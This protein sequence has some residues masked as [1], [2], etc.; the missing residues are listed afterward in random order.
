MNFCLSRKTLA[1]WL[2]FLLVFANPLLAEAYLDPGT[3]SLIVQAVIAA[4]AAVGLYIGIFWRKI[5][6]Y[7]SW[8]GQA[9]N[10][11][12]EIKRT[13]THDEESK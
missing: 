12:E 7:F 3:G 9:R 6:S 2:F 5:R 8:G 4:L 10:D 1:L 13:K 11:E